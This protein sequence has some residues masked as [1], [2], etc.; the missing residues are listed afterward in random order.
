MQPVLQIIA[1]VGPSDANVLI[2]GENGTGKG[3]VAQALHAVSAR[4]SR[5]MVDDQRRRRL[6]G[7][8]RERAVRPRQRRVHRRQAGSRRPLRAGRR[9]HAVPRRDRQR[10][11]QPAAEAAARAGD[12]RVRALGSSRTRK[13]DVRLISATNADLNAEVAAGRFRQDLLFRLNT[14]EIRLPPLRERRDDIP[15][16]AKHFLAAR[17]ALSERR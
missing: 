12:R 10:A 11:A 7:R 9:Q 13:A 14:I 6:G 5:P 1:R 8:V 16:I 17:A 3:V 2:T 15:R 4:A